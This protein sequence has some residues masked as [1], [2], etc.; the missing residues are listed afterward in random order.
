MRLIFDLLEAGASTVVYEAA[1][2]LTALTNNPV[3]V[4]GAAAKKILRN[5]PL[6]LHV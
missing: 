5:E 6:P 2:S 4:K 3:A 1:S